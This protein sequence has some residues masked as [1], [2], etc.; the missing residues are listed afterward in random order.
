MR[1]RLWSSSQ[2]ISPHCIG[3]LV[4][5]LHSF[6]HCQDLTATA[7]EQAFWYAESQT[8]TVRRTAVTCYGA[9]AEKQ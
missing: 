1:M 9:N 3:D 2:L 6:V 8:K 5:E 4:I 7:Q